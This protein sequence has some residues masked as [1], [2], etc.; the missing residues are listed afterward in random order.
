MNNH[1]E[2]VGI[3]SPGPELD[4]VERDEGIRTIALQMSRKI[5][6]TQDIISLIEMVK[7]IRQENPLAIHSHTPKAGIISML[8]GFICRVPH[9]FHTVAGLPLEESKGLKR[10]LLILIEKITYICAT[11]IYPNSNGLKEF[12]LKFI[13][14]NEKK[15]KVIGYGSSNGIDTNYFHTNKNIIEESKKLHKK[16]MLDKKFVFSFIG[17]IVKDKGINELLLAFE[18]LNSQYPNT[19]LLVIGWQEPELNPISDQSLHILNNNKNVIVE[20]YADDIRPFLA[21]TDCFVLPSYREGF[22]NTVLQACSMNIPSIVSN[23]NGCN[24]IIKNNKNGILVP[25]KD[26]QKLLIA[27]KKIRDDKLFLE[28]P[29]AEIRKEIIKKYDRK[30]FH[31]KVLSEYMSIF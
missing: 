2:V 16:Y 31:K 6:I 14:S 3:S 21:C 18:E 15:I 29:P 7:I 24:E 20:G 5:S 13:Y 11:R 27:M 25:P 19:R 8:A 10:I 23:I 30:L 22:P 4:M 1:F 26:Y 12:I 17:R 28:A 9:R